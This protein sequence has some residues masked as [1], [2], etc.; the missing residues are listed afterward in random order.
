M[1]TVTNL[2]TDALVEVLSGNLQV[3]SRERNNAWVYHLRSYRDHHKLEFDDDARLGHVK[4][5]W[6]MV[7]PGD[8]DQAC[9]THYH[10]HPDCVTAARGSPSMTDIITDLH[11]VFG[12]F[13]DA[14][15]EHPPTPSSDTVILYTVLAY[16]NTDTY[17]CVAALC[18]L[19]R[20]K[21]MMYNFS[22]TE[23]FPETLTLSQFKE[24]AMERMEVVDQFEH[25]KWEQTKRACN[26]MECSTDQ[27][28]T[29]K[30]SGCKL[31][32]YCSRAC[33]KADWSK[34]K[35]RCKSQA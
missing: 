14:E 16:L 4:Q 33:Q 31:A 10:P 11:A 27:P 13:A 22:R 1:S 5:A 2:T 17:S 21:V 12:R 34:H 19:N 9:W 18:F 6:A 24:V 23:N 7:K 29:L 30:C 35:Q 15:I 8:S 26:N 32:N 28:A 25:E 20:G 3:L